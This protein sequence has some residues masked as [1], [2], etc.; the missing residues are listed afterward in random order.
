MLVLESLA[1][2]K[3]AEI[4]K[5]AENGVEGPVMLSGAELA[6]YW[7]ATE[8]QK[9]VLGD[10]TMAKRYRDCSEESRGF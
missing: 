3:D 8:H 1:L 5:P 7:F 6:S 9:A 2:L 4:P 10:R